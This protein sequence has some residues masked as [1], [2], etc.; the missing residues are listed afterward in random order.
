MI[1]ISTLDALISKIA[2]AAR[3]EP[4]T[5]EPYICTD[6]HDPERFGT[7]LGT[8]YTAGAGDTSIT[9]HIPNEH[10]YPHINI[11][12]GDIDVD[13]DAFVRCIP[14][15]LAFLADSRFQAARTSWQQGA[16][17]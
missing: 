15:V 4:V 12:V 14:G 9:A 13:L 2:D 10:T 3:A 1:D 5:A 16:Q 7:Q 17:R 6:L 11:I 8:D